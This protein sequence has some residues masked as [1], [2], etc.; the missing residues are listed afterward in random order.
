MF[1][2]A[3]LRRI[4][5]APP[6]VRTSLLPIASRTSFNSISA[7]QYASVPN[8]AQTSFWLSL[9]P[10]PLRK[11][12]PRAALKKKAKSKEWNPATFFIIIFLLIG[13]MSIQMI[14]LKNESAAFTRRADAKIGLLKEIIERIQNGEE[15]DV[16]G[17]LGSGDKEMEKEWEE[18][19]QDIER[20]DQEWQQSRRT[21]P[22]HGRNLES[23]DNTP[24]TQTPEAKDIPKAPEAKGDSTR[25]APVG[26]Y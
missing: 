8:V 10:K 21:K 14:A 18:V 5:L 11:S 13:S 15:V 1:R 12:S 4:L 7:R 26:F 22:K 20:E 6:A 25:K 17:L 9:I 24:I 2:S 16:E 19:L 23:T 3:I